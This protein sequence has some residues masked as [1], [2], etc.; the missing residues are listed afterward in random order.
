[1]STSS[2]QPDRQELL[3]KIEMLQKRLAAAEAAQEKAE[4]RTERKQRQLEEAQKQREEA[5]KERERAPKERDKA[6]QEKNVAVAAQGLALQKVESMSAT[7]TETLDLIQD[8]T[9]AVHEAARNEH[10]DDAAKLLEDLQGSI[11]HLLGMAQNSQ[12]WCSMLFRTGNESLREPARVIADIQK[13]IKDTNK[14][15]RSAKALANNINRI[16]TMLNTVI[17]EDDGTQAAAAAAA[18][19]A[20]EPTAADTVSTEKSEDKTDMAKVRKDMNTL[21]NAPRPTHHEAP[22]AREPGEKN[23]N[24]KGRQ[25]AD[26][27]NLA[28]VPA[29]NPV[30]PENCPKCRHPFVGIQD[31]KESV[32]SALD[33]YQTSLSECETRVKVLLCPECGEIHIVHNEGQ[34]VPVVPNRMLA[35]DLI[36][37]GIWELCHGR[38]I[39]MYRKM[40]LGEL[41]IGSNTL[42]DN[43]CDWAEIYGELLIGAIVKDNGDCILLVDE[44]PFATNEGMGKGRYGKD[45]SNTSSQTYLLTL[46]T[47]T[48]S[49]RRFIRFYYMNSR[50]KESIGQILEGFKDQLRYL[51]TDGYQ[52]YDSLLKDTL[53]EANR[54]SCLAH[55]RRPSYES[56]TANGIYKELCALKPEKLREHLQ[57]ALDRNDPYVCLLNLT[58]GFSLLYGYEAEVKEPLPEET[59]E[60]H[61]ERINRNRQEKSRPV[62][63]AMDRIYCEL[64]RGCLEKHG[65]KYRQKK[66]TPYTKPVLYWM[67]QREHLGTFLEDPRIPLDTNI[68]ERGL[69]PATIIRKVINFKQSERGMKAMATMLSLVETGGYYQIDVKQWLRDFGEAAYWHALRRGW[70]EAMN[71]E[72]A[73]ANYKAEAE[74][75]GE[76]FD[77]EAV[78]ARL[79]KGEKKLGTNIKSWDMPHLLSD[80]DLTPYLPKN[81]EARLRAEANSEP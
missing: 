42:Y 59:R 39:N 71:P 18:P 75:A 78:R 38:S 80:F 56:L 61:L 60:Q 7:L 40:S 63:E 36:L 33:S 58:D 74:A 54:Q 4:Q 8:V 24:L 17:R 31:A 68:V 57:K 73:V 25:P 53:I 37:M 2:Q 20:T 69:R 13:I 19:S 9:G 77:E 21:A 52:V 11:K 34:P 41:K 55:A 79:P 51:C 76:K 64:A 67:N 49:D 14:S 15:I 5:Q 26:R 29:Q 70:M 48:D 45:N 35:Q 65:E 66:V 50:S 81:Y 27:S 32:C 10:P 23:P 44:T 47:T 6:I 22:P 62:F 1:M 16:L 30:A 3:E 46:S 43:I 72:L 12:H 28:R